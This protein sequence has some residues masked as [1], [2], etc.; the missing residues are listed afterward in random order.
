M[1]QE[2]AL[3]TIIVVDDEEIITRPI[4]RLLKGLIRR[5]NLCYQVIAAQSP[6]D[7]LHLIE[8]DADDLALVISDIIMQPMN[9]LEFLRRVKT[10]CPET[11]LIVLTGYADELAYSALKEQLELYSYQEKPWDDEQLMRVVRNALDSYRR[12]KLLNRYVPK[13]VVE[14]ALT[15][16]DDEILE[17]V[18]LVVTILFLDFR[19]STSLFRSEILS[20]KQAL[21]HLNIYFKALLDVLDKHNG[22]LDKFMGDGLMA[23]F[24]APLPATTPAIDA[25]NATL[26][27]LEMREA[28]LQLNQRTE[29]P[30]T[31][32]VGISTGLVVAGNIGTE[33]R[34]D[35]TVLGSDVNIAARLQK[36]AK[37]IQNGIFVSQSTYEYVKDIVE[38]KRRHPL[39]SDDKK[40]SVPVY[41]L[42]GQIPDS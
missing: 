19:D 28:V 42:L 18:E 12:R 33:H 31:I 1:E 27:A 9:G 24:G 2:K 36:A 8:S 30:M 11:L 7:V 39:P 40:G 37:S 15:R 13:R 21:E 10:Y 41:E 22:I 14:Q 29:L 4:V 23:L 3:G 16:P 25:R 32:G 17:G 35:Y 38:V 34:G 5:K 26:A 20:P 6:L